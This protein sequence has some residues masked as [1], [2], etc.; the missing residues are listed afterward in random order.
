MCQKIHLAETYITLMGKNLDDKAKDA[1]IMGMSHTIH[2]IHSK[3]GDVEK[4]L[5]ELRRKPKTTYEIPDWTMVDESDHTCD[6]RGKSFENIGTLQLHM[7]M[8]MEP[9]T[10]FR[11]PGSNGIPHC[12]RLANDTPRLHMTGPTPPPSIPPMN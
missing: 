6:D 7:H 1:T 3:H 11:T 4:M 9:G 10:G 5:A 8:G 2:T 12:D